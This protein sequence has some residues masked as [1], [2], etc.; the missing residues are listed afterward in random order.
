MSDDDGYLRS[1]YFEA[2]VGYYLTGRFAWLAGAVPVAGN[3]FHHAVEMFLKG[4]LAATTTEEER[5]GLSHN[6]PRTWVQYKRTVLDATLDQFDGII[7]A[8][9]HFEN[10]R[11]PEKVENYIVQFAST[12][13]FIYPTGPAVGMSTPTFT[14]V[15][16]E[17]DA[18]VAELLRHANYSTWRFAAHFPEG[19]RAF[20][21]RDNLTGIW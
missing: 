20:L 1:R 12:G 5:K 6:L 21:K 19:A 3:L 4:H 15:V 17:I 10:L 7:E 14:V 8:V 13:P 9:D 11:Y 18:L 16:N 2:G